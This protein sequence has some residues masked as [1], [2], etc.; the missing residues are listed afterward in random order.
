LQEKVVTAIEAKSDKDFWAYAKQNGVIVHA[1][2]ANDFLTPD[3][4]QDGIRAN[5]GNGDEYQPAEEEERTKMVLAALLAMKSL[6]KIQ[7]NIEVTPGGEIRVGAVRRKPYNLIE[8]TA[9]GDVPMQLLVCDEQGQAAYGLKGNDCLTKKMVVNASNLLTK[10]FLKSRGGLKIG[11]TKNWRKKLEKFI[12]GL[13]ESKPSQQLDN[14]YVPPLITDVYLHDIVNVH[15][16][17]NSGKNPTQ[18]SGEIYVSDGQGGYIP[19]G[20]TFNAVNTA[21]YNGGRAWPKDSPI[22]SLSQWLVKNGYRDDKKITNDYLHEIVDVYRAMHEG[23]NPTLDSGDIYVRDGQG[24]YVANGDTFLA[25]Y[26][27]MRNGNRGWPKDSPIRSLSQW[28]DEN[29]YR[30]K[31]I[32]NDYLH[33]IVD[34]YRA[35]HQGKNPTQHSGDIYVSD[36]QGGYVPNGDTFNTVDRAMYR[37]GRGWPKASTI[38]SLS[39]WLKDNGYTKPKPPPTQATE[40]YAGAA[41]LRSREGR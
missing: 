32:N 21:M 37:G 27:A 4:L 7:G 22:K 24:G 30:D 16:E 38:K 36:G 12:E 35:M 9:V 2:A 29:G 13:I 11:F 19:N 10:S 1:R 5:E 18:Q 14:G 39:Q 26:M 17:R 6:G 31:Q 41:E 34:V 23:K 3:E 33:E 28:L 40:G 8:Y 25:V 20:D 15:R